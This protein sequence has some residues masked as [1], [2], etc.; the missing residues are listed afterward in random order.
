MLACD[1]CILKSYLY[2]CKKT[3][4]KVDT[5]HLLRHFLA[6]VIYIILMQR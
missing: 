2:F 5:V 3:F 4:K 1:L 6:N